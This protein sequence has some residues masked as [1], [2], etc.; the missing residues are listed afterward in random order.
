MSDF[1]IEKVGPATV[2]LPLLKPGQTLHVQVGP[3]AKVIDPE[4]CVC[5]HHRGSHEGHTVLRRQP[6]PTFC[7]QHCGCKAY[8]PAVRVTRPTI[9]E[10]CEEVAAWLREGSGGD[11]DVTGRDIFEISTTGELWPVFQLYQCKQA[12]MNVAV[13]LVDKYYGPAIGALKA[14]RKEAESSAPI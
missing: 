11:V 4:M 6:A 8:T 12:G 14:R 2:T 10:A 13:L 7:S 9:K 3:D 5:G 1:K